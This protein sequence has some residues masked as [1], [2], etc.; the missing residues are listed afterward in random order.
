VRK[1]VQSHTLPAGVP[2][3]PSEEKGYDGFA[4]LWFDSAEDVAR[5]FGEPRY[6]E[7]IRV[8]EPKFLDLA[9]C[10]VTITEE[11]LIHAD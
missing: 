1:Y 8:D 11:V 9:A 5:A 10:S 4:E 2:G 3:F 6:L 7:I